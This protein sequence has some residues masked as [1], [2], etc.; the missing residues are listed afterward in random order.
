[1]T[2]RSRIV[3]QLNSA[4]NVVSSFVG[5]G[6]YIPQTSSKSVQHSYEAKEMPTLE[7]YIHR[8]NGTERKQQPPLRI[9]C[10]GGITRSSAVAERPSVA[11]CRW[12]SCYVTQDHSRSFE[13]LRACV[14]SYSYS[15]VTMS[16]SCTVDEDNSNGLLC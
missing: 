12:K 5:S 3:N 11:P 2:I 14:S 6:D 10:C 8:D 16:L 15:I 7:R 13:I 1:M 4:R 9:A